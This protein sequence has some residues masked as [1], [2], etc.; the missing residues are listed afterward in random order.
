M[1]SGWAPRSIKQ[2]VTVG[3]RLGWGGESARAVLASG[4]RSSEAVLEDT[5]P[6]DIAAILFTSGSTGI[7]KGVVYRH[8]HFLAQVEMLRE[9]FDIRPGD[10]NLPTFPP[11][12]LFDPALGMTSVI[13]CMDP[14]RPAKADPE[15]LVETIKRFAVTNIFGS[16][17][18]PSAS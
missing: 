14:T 8:R 1:S 16:P 17:A 5:G 10:V 6:D 18:F 15:I 9:A 7:P 11:F 4:A 2:C 13:P 3:P 12:A